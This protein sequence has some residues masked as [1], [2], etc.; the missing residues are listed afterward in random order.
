MLLDDEQPIAG[1]IVAD[2][3]EAAVVRRAQAEAD[4][5]VVGP[6]QRPVRGR[7][8]HDDQRLAAF[9]GYHQQVITEVG[10]AL[11]IAEALEPVARQQAAVGIQ[12][13]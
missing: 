6:P 9:L 7:Q 1:A 11:D 10:H 5:L 8:W 4:R 12:G 3:F 13:K 2:T